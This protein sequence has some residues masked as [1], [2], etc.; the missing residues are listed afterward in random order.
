[1]SSNASLFSLLLCAFHTL[2]AFLKFFSHTTANVICLYIVQFAVRKQVHFVWFSIQ[3]LQIIQWD[4]CTAIMKA[5]MKAFNWLRT[6][7]LALFIWVFLYDIVAILE[8]IAKE[9]LSTVHLCPHSTFFLYNFNILTAHFNECFFI[10]NFNEFL[11]LKLRNWNI[12]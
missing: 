2:H 9:L 12:L 6:L 4:L 5:N 8:L 3:N 10:K 1:M 7:F 11:N